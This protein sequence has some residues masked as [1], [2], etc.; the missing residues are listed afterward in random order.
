MT[1]RA[2]I[3]T[4]VAD[5]IGVVRSAVLGCKTVSHSGPISGIDPRNPSG[6]NPRHHPLPAE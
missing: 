4:G 2:Q 6:F 1:N 3:I 5:A